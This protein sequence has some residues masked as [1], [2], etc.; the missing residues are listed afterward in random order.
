MK[1]TIDKYLHEAFRNSAAPLYHI[2]NDTLA[3]IIV[4]AATLVALES[5]VSI[6]N[7]YL[8]FFDFAEY[9]ILT[10]FTTEY[11]IYIYLAP[12]KRA[13]IFSVLGIIDLLAI[14][15]TYFG[16]V[17]FKPLRVLRVVRVLRLL[18][19]VRLLKLI[20]YSRKQH[21]N[22][23][24]HLEEIP[25]RNIEIF[26]FALFSVVIIAGTFIFLA[27]ESVTNSP[28]T[29]IPISAWW[30]LVTLT[31]VGYG[32]MIPATVAGKIVAAFTMI[33]GL[34]LLAVLVSVVGN[35]MQK[36]LFGTPDEIKK[37]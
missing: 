33:A 7:T 37:Q 1:R 11:L 23:K 25:W 21:P 35:A 20:S 29:N 36:V 9:V 8:P 10:I 6:R 5:V 18:R 15:P 17:F 13:Y 4:V 31:T 14:L 3:V 30:A 32:D 16:L 22:K 27:E 24:I 34:M 12:K 28:F 2:I 19:V 26:F